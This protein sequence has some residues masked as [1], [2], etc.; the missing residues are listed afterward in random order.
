MRATPQ[1]QKVF[2][3][4]RNVSLVYDN[5]YTSVKVTGANTHLFLSRTQILLELS[6][7]NCNSSTV[8]ALR[9]LEDTQRKI[10]IT[11]LV[12]FEVHVEKTGKQEW[13][14]LQTDVQGLST[15][16]V[17]LLR[18]TEIMRQHHL[19]SLYWWLYLQLV[20]INFC[21]KLCKMVLMGLILQMAKIWNSCLLVSQYNWC[22]HEW[23]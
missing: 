13:Q 23:L 14:S 2:P 19:K 3:W 4:I 11:N 22:M 21:L 1:E 5:L 6:L 9:A 15:G 12:L 17:K 7:K 10:F 16:M 18:D 8:A 20:L